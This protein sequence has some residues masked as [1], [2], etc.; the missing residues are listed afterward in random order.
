[1]RRSGR[2]RERLY[3]CCVVVV[4]F[5]VLFWLGKESLLREGIRFALSESVAASFL[6]LVEVLS[7][8]GG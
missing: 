5:M 7:R 6:M 2:K 8:Q 3:A 4:G 1:M